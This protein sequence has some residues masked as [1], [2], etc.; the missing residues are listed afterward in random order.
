[1]SALQDTL[2]PNRLQS[3]H[4]RIFAFRGAALKAWDRNGSGGGLKTFW[5]FSR[6]HEIRQGDR[7]LWPRRAGP[8]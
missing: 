1:M 6:A 5:V 8:T 2:P 7:T 3:Q 4:A